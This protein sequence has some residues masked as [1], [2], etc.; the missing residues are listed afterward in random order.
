MSQAVIMEVVRF[1][2]PWKQRHY[3]SKMKCMQ[4]CHLALNL[5]A[6]IGCISLENVDLNVGEE[7]FRPL[8]E[9]DVQELQ[10]ELLEQLD[11]AAGLPGLHLRLIFGNILLVGFRLFFEHWL[12]EYDVS[13]SFKTS[14]HLVEDCL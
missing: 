4:W 13:S 1:L 6:S 9:L 5:S 14:L 11:V 12:H 3:L 2:L 10:A 7:P 8:V